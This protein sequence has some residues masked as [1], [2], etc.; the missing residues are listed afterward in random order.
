MHSGKRDRCGCTAIM[1]FIFGDYEK[2]FAAELRDVCRTRSESD[3][4]C[5]LRLTLSRQR[6]FPPDGGSESN[7]DTDGRPD[8]PVQ[9]TPSTRLTTGV[10][11]TLRAKGDG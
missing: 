9:T 5:D 10:Q 7:A 4:A 3:S 2:L 8:F 11:G 6:R 1:R